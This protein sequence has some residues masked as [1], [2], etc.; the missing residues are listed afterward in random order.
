M[1]KA[2]VYIKDWGWIKCSN[3]NISITENNEGELYRKIKTNAINLTIPYNDVKVKE[4][5]E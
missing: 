3:T 5:E 4:L 1:S 2:V